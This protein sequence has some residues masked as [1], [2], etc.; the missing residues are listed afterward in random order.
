MQL[1][2]ILLFLIIQL[3]NIG[4]FYV[5]LSYVFIDGNESYLIGKGEFVDQPIFINALLTHGLSAPI[6][7]LLVSTLVLL[8][9]EK[10]ALQLHRT[11]G[12]IAL[13]VA[14]ILVVPSGIGLSFYAMG[15]P[16]GK[17]LFISLSFYTG[18]TVIAGY[19]AIKARHTKK[20]Q[21]WMNELL[22]LLCSAIIL[23]LLITFFSLVLDWK[24]DTMYNTA[25][26]LSWV[27]W[28]LLLKFLHTKAYNAN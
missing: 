15:G 17:F 13:F 20:H 24:G 16:V 28:I 5:G 1:A 3:F 23:R 4:I 8:R 22:I 11:L 12:K 26:F 6:T 9:I 10:K 27:P 25:A 2:R 21:H 19:Q 7:L 14:V 18:Y